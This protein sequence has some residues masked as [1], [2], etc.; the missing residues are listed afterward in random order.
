MFNLTYFQTRFP[1]LTDPGMQAVQNKLELLGVEVPS[2]GRT[3]AAPTPVDEVGSNS[4]AGVSPSLGASFHPGLMAASSPSL[5]LNFWQLPFP[6]VQNLLQ[7]GRS[8][9][10]RSWCQEVP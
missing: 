2:V 5:N 3:L 7:G 9:C 1:I 8:Q 4:D 10:G 6:G